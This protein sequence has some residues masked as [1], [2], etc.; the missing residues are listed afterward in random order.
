[1][2]G[3]HDSGRSLAHD[4]WLWIAIPRTNLR[5]LPLGFLQIEAG[6]LGF[7]SFRSYRPNVPPERVSDP[8]FN[9]RKSW[10]SLMG[11]VVEITLS[12]EPIGMAFMTGYRNHLTIFWLCLEIP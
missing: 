7:R 6:G 12:F 11:F 9:L 2:D 5:I 1:M 4:F 8:F 10:Q 3:F